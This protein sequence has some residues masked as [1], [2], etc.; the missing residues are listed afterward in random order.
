MKSQSGSI[1]N[2]KARIP[3]TFLEPEI[4]NEEGKAGGPTKYLSAP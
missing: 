2:Q 1:M 3:T 4:D